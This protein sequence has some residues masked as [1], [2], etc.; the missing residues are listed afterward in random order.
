MPKGVKPRHLDPNHPMNRENN[1]PPENDD[2]D[3]TLDPLQ[4]SKVL[5]LL[6]TKKALVN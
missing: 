4:G 6:V 1:R 5:Y 3:R 2:N